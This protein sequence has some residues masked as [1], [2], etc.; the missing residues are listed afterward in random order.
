M[1]NPAAADNK[2][3]NGHTLYS[4]NGSLVANGDVPPGLYSSSATHTIAEVHS[5]PSGSLSDERIIMQSDSEEEKEDA[6]LLKRK[7][8][9]RNSGCGS[10]SSQER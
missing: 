8:S 4:A 3:A 10:L 1:H 9:G 6:P 5:D 7:Q 2:A